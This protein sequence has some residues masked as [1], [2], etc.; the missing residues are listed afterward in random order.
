MLDQFGSERQVKRVEPV[1]SP[2]KASKSARKPDKDESDDSE[3]EPEVRITAT[4]HPLIFVSSVGLL[5]FV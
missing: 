2:K 1:A 4:T 3:S 5:N